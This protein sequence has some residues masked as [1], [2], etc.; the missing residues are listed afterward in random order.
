M[1]SYT[2]D[3]YVCN[4][5]PVVHGRNERDE[6]QPILSA[7]SGPDLYRYLWD[8]LFYPQ[9]KD[10]IQPVAGHGCYFNR[11]NNYEFRERELAGMDVKIL[12]LTRQYG[13]IQKEV[14]AAVYEL[15]KSGVYIG[16]EA[17][18]DF[19]KDFAA[20]IGV[21]HAVAV[22]SGTDALVIALKALG[23]APGDEVITTPFTF[24]ATAEAIAMIGAVPVFADI[25]KDTYNI[26]PEKI[27]AK[28]TAKTKAV[29]PVHI[30][31]QPADM[32]AIKE[33]ADTHNLYIIED[34]C[35]AVGASIGDT[36]VGAMGDAACFSFFPTKNLGAF[37]DG[38]MITTNDDNT[39]II[40]RALKEH[41][42]AQN[43]AKAR[44]L[45]EG[46]KD[47]GF[48]RQTGDALY[49]PYKYYNYLIAHNSR[50][51][52]IQAKILSIKLK[53]LDA[54]NKKRAA[55]AE[56][57]NEAFKGCDN[58]VV[59]KIK[60]GVQTVWHQYAICCRDKDAIGDFLAG[61]GIG[62]AAFYPV[63]LHLQKAFDYLG[64]KEGE[65]PVA[66]SVTK[67]TVCLPIFPE[68]TKEELE[69]VIS[70]VKEFYVYN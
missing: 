42:G 7:V 56:I 51:D 55:I 5:F 8:K 32:A 53:H 64:Y 39:A 10:N 25:E 52:A 11:H 12:D 9:R 4:E 24:F 43:G 67:Q 23:V 41:G 16:G 14:E 69:Y 45:L 6:P 31:G 36:K 18:A 65:F 20:Y 58:I 19:E 29:L 22:N 21:K 47:E 30:F 26:D 48:A 28:I 62:S 35:Q 3:G 49:N 44:E 33:I 40:C 50:L 17:V 38:G 1:D 27:E 61:K 66:E 37:G 46:V 57:Y 13:F 34:A 63:P 60:E 59:P 15:M 54:F 70:N 2:G 68:L